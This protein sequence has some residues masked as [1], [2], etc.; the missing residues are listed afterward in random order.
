MS[1]LTK[2][3]TQEIGQSL[4][5]LNFLIKS[6]KN[7]N[8]SQETKPEFLPDQRYLVYPRFPQLYKEVPTGS[9][10]APNR[11]LAAKDHN[12]LLQRI[13]NQA[14]GWFFSLFWLCVMATQFL[15]AELQSHKSTPSTPLHWFPWIEDDRKRRKDSG[16]QQIFTSVLDC[17]HERILHVPMASKQNKPES[18]QTSLRRKPLF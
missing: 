12:W 15:Q 4:L 6:V 10:S 11:T 1:C 9:A 5:A 8:A 7:S 13:K 14:E 18:K 2:V 17:T 16:K 3:R